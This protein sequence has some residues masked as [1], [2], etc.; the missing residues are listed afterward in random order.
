MRSVNLRSADPS[1]WRRLVRDLRVWWCRHMHRR[2]H[3]VHIYSMLFQDVT[4]S[5]C[6]MRWPR[7]RWE[8]N[9]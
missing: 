7:F 5:R 4:C 9:R 1:R 6:G 2:H 8:G 3:V